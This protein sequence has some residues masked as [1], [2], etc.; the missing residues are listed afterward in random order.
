VGLQSAA[1]ESLIPIWQSKVRGVVPS[2]SSKKKV[3]D[4]SPGGE[5]KLSRRQKNSRAKEITEKHQGH[6]NNGSVKIY[7]FRCKEDRSKS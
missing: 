2:S 1:R 7:D 3:A 5:Q 4:L 6:V